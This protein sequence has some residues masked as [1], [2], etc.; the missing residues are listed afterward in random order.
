MKVIHFAD[1][2]PAIGNH[3]SIGMI[4]GRSTRLFLE[5]E[6]KIGESVEVRR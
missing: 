6:Q 2:Y 4:T 3:G 5:A 1:L